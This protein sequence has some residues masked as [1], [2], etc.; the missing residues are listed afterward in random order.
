MIGKAWPLVRTL[1]ENHSRAAHYNP[2]MLTYLLKTCDEQSGAHSTRD[3]LLQPS[4]PRGSTCRN[5]KLGQ[6]FFLA[7]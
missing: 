1:V 3:W 4:A 2:K 7:E 5:W 6:Y